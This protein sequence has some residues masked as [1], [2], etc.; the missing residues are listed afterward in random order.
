MHNSASATNGDFF[1]SA[2]R[3]LLGYLRDDMHD[4]FHSIGA[5]ARLIAANSPVVV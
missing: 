1:L 5:V 3:I 2:N 4:H